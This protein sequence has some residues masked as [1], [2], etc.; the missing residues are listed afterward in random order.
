MELYFLRHAIAVE[1]DNPQY[2][3]DA[4]RPLTAPGKKK[5]YHAA[6]GMLT[7]GLCFDAILC[8]PYTRARQTAQIVAKVFKIKANKIKFTNNLV[9]DT[10]LSRLSQEILALPPGSKNILLVGHQPHLTEFISYLL[11]SAKPVPINLKKGGLCNLSWP[12]PCNPGDA[13]LNWI[14]TSSQLCLMAPK[15]LSD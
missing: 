13:C 8:S 9:G 12:A 1:R 14:M 2:R 4:M 5:M 10:A 7:L 6:R 15:V 11:K 3:D